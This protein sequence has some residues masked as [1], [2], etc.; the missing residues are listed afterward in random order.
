[1]IRFTLP[2]LL[3]LFLFDTNCDAC[4]VMPTE[5][6]NWHELQAMENDLAGHYVLVNDLDE[7]TEGY[8]DYQSGKGFRPVGSKTK[9]HVNGALIS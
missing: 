4:R 5:I 7:N 6:S 8:A 1:M 9:C 2:L 3:S